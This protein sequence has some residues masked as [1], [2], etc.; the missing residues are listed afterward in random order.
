MI[1]SDPYGVA[2]A[3][4]A[5]NFFSPS[6]ECPTNSATGI[7]LHPI[8]IGMPGWLVIMIVRLPSLLNSAEVVVLLLLPLE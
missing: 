6:T 8:T 5:M 7:T 3:F 2:L 4:M 1:Q